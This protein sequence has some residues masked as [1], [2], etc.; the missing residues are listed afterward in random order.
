MIVPDPVQ[1][2]LC[3]GVGMLAM[4]TVRFRHERF[5][6][7]VIQF[8]PAHKGCLGDVIPA[9]YKINVFRLTV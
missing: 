1:F 6:G 3:V 5:P 8:V 9:K 2:F 7:A 4:W